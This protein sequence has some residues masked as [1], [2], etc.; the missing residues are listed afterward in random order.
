MRPK[1]PLSRG[2]TANVVYRIQCSSCE[3][4]YIGET[5]KRLQ[6]RMS[7]HARAVDRM[8][9]RSLVA[10]HCSSPGH[11]FAFN[12]AEILARGSDRTTRETLEA[13]HTAPNSINRCTILPAAYQ[14]LRVRLNQR[15][16]RQEV[17]RVA[18]TSNPTPGQNTGVREP[19][20]DTHT[21]VS[22]AAGNVNQQDLL[23]GLNAVAHNNG[24]C[25]NTDGGVRYSAGGTNTGKCQRGKPAGHAAPTRSMQTRAMTAG[26]RTLPSPSDEVTARNPGQQDDDGAP[27]PPPQGI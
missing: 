9:P 12:D 1:A 19:T 3:A 14:A 11:T 20:P 26:M 10:E 5:G 18:T 24:P 27:A 22:D 2:E 15:N 21:A 8:D 25:I 13:W 6:T 17:R 4:N 23:S 7:E 16:R